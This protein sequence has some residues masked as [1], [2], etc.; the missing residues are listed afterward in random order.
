[1][2]EI[3]EDPTARDRIEQDACVLA[4]FNRIADI[5]RAGERT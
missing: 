2:S 1:V 3:R 4:L 5:V